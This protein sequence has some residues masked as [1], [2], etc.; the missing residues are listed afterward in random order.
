M[1]C[2][3]LDHIVDK[4]E[5]YGKEKKLRNTAVL[6]GSNMNEYDYSGERSAYRQSIQQPQ[7]NRMLNWTNKA[8]QNATQQ[9]NLLHELRKVTVVSTVEQERQ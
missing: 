8:R 7:I 9:L 2:L 6:D 3:D 1:R 5:R 4:I